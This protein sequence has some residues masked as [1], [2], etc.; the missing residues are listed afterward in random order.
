MVDV[1]SAVGTVANIAIL[2]AGL[3]LFSGLVGQTQRN[4]DQPRRTT[5]RRRTN[6]N[7]FDFDLGVQ[8]RRTT[9]RRSN[10]V[11]DGRFF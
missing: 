9:R 3:A 10:D 4:L 8:P 2:G 1:S 5:R 6:N 7:L 11:F